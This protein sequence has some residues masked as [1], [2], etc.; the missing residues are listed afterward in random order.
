[1]TNIGLSGL[2]TLALNIILILAVP[3]AVVLAAFVVAR[4]LRNLENRVR[5]LEESAPGQG[6]NPK[7]TK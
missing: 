4:R 3:A 5:R 6:R 1:M 2:A 7:Q